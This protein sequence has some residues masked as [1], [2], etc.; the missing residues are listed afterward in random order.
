MADQKIT[1]L[2]ANTTPA[3]T[4]IIPMVDDPG[5]TPATQKITYADAFKVIGGLTEDTAPALADFIPTYDDSASAAKKVSPT[6]FLEITNLLT[7][8]TAVDVAADFLLTYDTSASTVKKAKPQTIANLYLGYD[9][10]LGNGK[11]SVTVASNDLTVAIK[12]LAGADPSA[13][14][15]VI[16]RING[17]V[18]LIT[19]ALSVTKADGT[20]WFN[21]GGA[22]T[23]TLTVPY[24][25]YLG[26]NATDG[27]VIGFSRISHG[28]QYSDFSAT[29]TNDHYCAISTITT[30]AST[31]YYMNIG[32]FE[33]TLSA[34]AG[35]TWTVP[36]F[37]A[38]NKVDKPTYESNWMTWTPTITGFSANPGTPIYTYQ[39]GYKKCIV[40]TNEGNGTS[41]ATTKT[42]TAPITSATRANVNYSGPVTVQVDNGTALGT[43][44]LSIGSNTTTI[45]A[46]RPGQAAWTGSGTCKAAAGGSLMYEI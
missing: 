6:N 26:Y 31:D 10:M 34:G 38:I 15:P 16:V 27:V 19:S 29:T 20:N 13:G 23:A 32:Y 35:Y 8:D 37:T 4:D 24:F 1:A 11:I 46:Y 12:T 14:D 7:E 30:A 43:G 22:E 17:V 33:A 25:V 39:I 28:R 40:I 45:N 3:V 18:R 5:G 42:Y 2:P 9:G 36:T 44:S 41:N 21:S